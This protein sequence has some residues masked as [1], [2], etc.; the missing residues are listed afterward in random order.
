M[1]VVRFNY[2]K[3]EDALWKTV[4]SFIFGL[5]YA[6]CVILTISC[7][8]MDLMLITNNK[9][10]DGIIWFILAIITFGI[11]NIVDSKLKTLSSDIRECFSKSMVTIV[12]LSATT[13]FFLGTSIYYYKISSKIDKEFV[14]RFGEYTNPETGFPITGA[15]SYLDAIDAQMRMENEEYEY[16]ETR[17]QIYGTN[18]ESTWGD[19]ID[20]NGG[21]LVYET[22]TPE[23]QALVNYP[24]LDKESVYFVPNGSNYH[25]V[26]WCYTL[27]QS[28]NII[29]CTLQDALNKRL[30]PCSKCVGE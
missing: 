24:Y 25:S 28:D 21:E 10:I 29:T 8:F 15:L 2:T 13:L 3:H 18:F 12:L 26:D 6:I 14:I 22:L 7:F 23:Q 1:A 19:L 30:D 11:Q 4:I 17:S 9:W 20:A 16:Q 27:K 5:I